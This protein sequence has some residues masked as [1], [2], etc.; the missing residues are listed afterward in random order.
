[1]LTSEN[2]DVCKAFLKRNPNFRIVHAANAWKDAGLPQAP[3][4]VGEYF[5]LSPYRAATDGFFACII[6]RTE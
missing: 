1:L 3:Q 2:E 5:R 4:G 6:E